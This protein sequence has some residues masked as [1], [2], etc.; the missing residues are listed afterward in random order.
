MWRT[1]TLN[2]D[3]K[4]AI[5]IIDTSKQFKNQNPQRDF[6]QFPDSLSTNTN[7]KHCFLGRL[8]SSLTENKITT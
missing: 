8:R 6:W 1:A 3:Y 5:N 4:H 7:M 2:L